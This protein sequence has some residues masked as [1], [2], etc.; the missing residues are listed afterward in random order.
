MRACNCSV[1]RSILVPCNDYILSYATPLLTW[2]GTASPSR[3]SCPTLIPSFAKSLSGGI[4]LLP[5]S[6]V[7]FIK[8]LRRSHSVPWGP[9]VYP[10]SDGNAC[11][12]NCL[13]GTH[14]SCSWSPYSRRSCC[15]VRRRSIPEELLPNLKRVLQANAKCNLKLSTSKTVISPIFTVILCWIWDSTLQPPPPPPPALQ[16]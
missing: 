10:F 11:L 13:G 9:V 5:I 8:P 4:S 14:L 6:R 16:P 7:P 15:Q 12:T 1:P 3:R 2:E